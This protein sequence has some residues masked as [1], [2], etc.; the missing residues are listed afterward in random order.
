MRVGVVVLPEVPGPE[1]ARIWRRVEELGVDHAW[2]FDHLSWRGARGGPW[3]DAFTVLASAA[4][5]TARITLG[6]LVTT[7]NF[8]HPVTTATQS[9]TIDHLS[10][11]RFA[12]GLGAGVTGP[13]A[14]SLGM[15]SLSP[16]I[17]A[18]RF[19]EFTTM[20]DKLLRQ[21]RSTLHGQFFDAVDVPMVPGCIRKPRIPFA[22]AATGRRGLR[23]AAEF[24]D[25]WVTIGNPREPGIESEKQAL[26]TLGTQ[27]DRL[28]GA[29]DEVG[30]DPR[31]LRKLVHLGRI[32]ADP[33]ASP[34]RLAELAGIC[35]D[36]GFTDVVVDHPRPA[37]AGAG[38]MSRFERAV[39]GICSAQSARRAQA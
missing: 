6:P 39:A 14:A 17:R 5:E 2:T 30:R 18:D 32:A 36:L 35:Q 37:Q 15:A 29:C 3:F 21:P 13:D 27:L 9:M 8:R 34:G 22:I 38:V 20:L 10:G 33:C 12:L 26:G 16:R 25:T 11:G 31:G 24:A 4:V 7:P 28:A 1:G 19:D 23:L